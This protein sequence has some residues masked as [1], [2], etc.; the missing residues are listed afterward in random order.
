[1][2]ISSSP[3]AV[4]NHTLQNIDFD[5]VDADIS[6][7][8]LDVG[9]EMVTAATEAEL[10]YI[11]AAKVLKSLTQDPLHPIS[12]RPLNPDTW[13][14]LPDTV[15]DRP[16]GLQAACNPI[17]DPGTFLL[18][19]GATR[20]ASPDPHPTLTRIILGSN[21]DKSLNWTYISF[22]RWPLPPQLTVFRVTNIWMSR[23]QCLRVLWSCPLVSV[24]LYNGATNILIVDSKLEEFTAAISEDDD[25]VDDACYILDIDGPAIVL[26]HLRKLSLGWSDLYEPWELL[27]APILAELHIVVAPV[28]GWA[29][30]MYRMFDRS[31][32][33]D[34][35]GF[36]RFMRRSRFTLISLTLHFDM[37]NQS[38][39]F[40]AMFDA[41]PTLEELTIR[42]HRPDIPPH[43]SFVSVL[44]HLT[45][46]AGRPRLLPRLQVLGT[47]LT[48]ESLAMVASRCKTAGAQKRSAR[49]HSLRDVTFYVDP[50]PAKMVPHSKQVAAIAARG[51][52]VHMAE[53]ESYGKDLLF[54]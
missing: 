9:E 53:M 33:F 47:D 30:S 51:V 14:D 46:R 5:P 20:G 42:W 43:P 10:Q 36:L 31:N 37:S 8:D 11:I 12:I 32:R 6:G 4:T 2:D 40:V 19:F 35:S 25:D 50:R 7:A 26:T 23:P 17:D 52:Q 54:V 27:T 16:N 38:A 28:E 3:P 15:P 48:V 21:I 44:W 13:L 49:L 18:Q 24:G 45:Y 34:H 29:E 22:M 1:M 39:E 41:L